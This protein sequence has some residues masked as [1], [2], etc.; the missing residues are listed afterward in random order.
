[1]TIHSLSAIDNRREL[2]WWSASNTNSEEKITTQLI[3]QDPK[4]VTWDFN[5][6]YR[7]LHT[8][9]HKKDEHRNIVTLVL[10]NLLYV[11]KLLTLSGTT[12]QKTP[13]MGKKQ[14]KNDQFSQSV[15]GYKWSQKVAIF[16]RVEE[17]GPT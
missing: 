13:N 1:M 2:L 14:A 15:A 12:K 5:R 6:P 17:K 3:Y 8:D 7:Y 9:L 4:H 16:R 10:I 11:L